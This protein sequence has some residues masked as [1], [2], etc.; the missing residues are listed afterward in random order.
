MTIGIDARFFGP[1]AKGL[2]RYAQKLTE[3]LE[4]IDDQNDY[5]VFLQR[6]DF[7]EW[8]PKNPR[9]KKV[10]ADYRWYSLAEQLIFPFKLYRQKVDLMHFAHFNVPVLYFGPYVVTIHDLILQYFGTARGSFFGRL[11]YRF[12]NLGYK[13]VIRIIVWRARKI[14]TI[15]NFVKDDIVKAFGVKPEKIK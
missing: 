1:R 4:K 6:A 14:I 15:S 2:G 13:I 10:L 12:K 3:E 9:F 11:K 8:R 7:D 5:L